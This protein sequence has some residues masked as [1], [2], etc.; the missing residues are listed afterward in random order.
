MA[1]N[2]AQLRIV[3][4]KLE[5][6]TGQIVKELSIECVAE[7]SEA[8][9]VNTGW[10]A[11]NWVPKIG[12]P[13]EAPKPQPKAEFTSTLVAQAAEQQIA[14]ASIAASYKLSNGL[15]SITNNVPYIQDLNE[16]TSKKAPA[17]F[18]QMAIAKAVENV[19]RK[20][21]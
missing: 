2:K 13:V 1:T 19:A 4:D 3:T 21:R 5:K 11:A 17:A 18:V 7:L 6:F 9:P 20:N 12:E 16:G 14:S 8:T 15:V 10:A